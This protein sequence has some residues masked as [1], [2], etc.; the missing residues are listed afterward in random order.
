MEA[1][2]VNEMIGINC[3]GARK[4]LTM[5][6]GDCLTSFKLVFNMK[7]LLIIP[8]L[9]LLLASCEN[10]KGK[11]V[12][13]PSD[14]TVVKIPMGKSFVILSYFAPTGM[15]Y[16]HL[17]DGINNNIIEYTCDPSNL[18]NV[19]N[20]GPQTFTVTKNLDDKKIFM[21]DLNGDLIP[22][23]ARITYKN[24]KT[25]NP[26]RVRINQ[27]LSGYGKDIS[28]LIPLEK[29]VEEYRSKEEGNSGVTTDYKGE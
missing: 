13:I 6:I 25:K 1:D 28:P 20:S 4:R 26:Y 8:V 15:Y 2:C 3:W 11:I 12:S 5:C 14:G 27:K 21:A 10:K 19:G 23:M 24:E 18:T 9:S 22:D 29:S 16:V 17:E 7:F